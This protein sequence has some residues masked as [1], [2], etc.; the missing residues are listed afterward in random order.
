MYNHPPEDGVKPKQ[1]AVINTTISIDLIWLKEPTDLSKC[2]ACN[3][4]IYSE[5]NVL[6]VMPSTNT[7]RLRGTKVDIVLCDACKELYDSN[8]VKTN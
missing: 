3:D 8:S 7:V 4:T 1:M 5:K 2:S 6:Y